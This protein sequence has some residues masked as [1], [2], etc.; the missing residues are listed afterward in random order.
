LDAL[1]I[2]EEPPQRSV[3][4][5][6]KQIPSGFKAGPMHTDGGTLYLWSREAKNG[7]VRASVTGPGFR[8]T[9]ALPSRTQATF[10]PQLGKISHTAFQQSTRPGSSTAV[11]FTLIV[12]RGAV[13][14]LG[15]LFDLF[16]GIQ[17]SSSDEEEGD[18][19]E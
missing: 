8:L 11:S 5:S 19:E 6:L 4:I 12:K 14:D 7:V 13:D 10:V 15:E 1:N 3:T 16:A 17:E 2:S 18:S 9:F